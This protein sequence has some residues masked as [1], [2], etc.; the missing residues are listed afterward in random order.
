[1]VFKR[2]SLLSLC[3]SGALVCTQFLQIN[4]EKGLSHQF[5]ESCIMSSRVGEE[6]LE[7]SPHFKTKGDIRA[8]EAWFWPGMR[9]ENDQEERNQGFCGLKRGQICLDLNQ[10]YCL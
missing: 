9:H 2:V 3:H 6:S 4:G 10:G 8:K 7:G 5:T 1:M